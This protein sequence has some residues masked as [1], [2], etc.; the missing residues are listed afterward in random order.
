M[1]F[2]KIIDCLEGNWKVYEQLFNGFSDTD[3]KWKPEEDRWSL[4]EVL[5]HLVDIEREDFRVDLDIILFHP[6]DPWP[7]FSIMDW[8]TERQYNDQIFHEK[9]QEFD[10][11]RK[12]S[13]QW[14]RSLENPDLEKRHSGNGFKREPLRAGDVMASWLA[15]DYYHFRQISLLNF[16]LLNREAETYS[17]LYSGFE[18]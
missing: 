5:C 12:R 11:E 1:D 14:L 9:L 16:D 8:V 2:Q 17:P 7:D 4:L 3:V 10:A 6:E 13:V 18:K 15:H